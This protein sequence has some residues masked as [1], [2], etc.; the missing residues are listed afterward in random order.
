MRISLI[1][2]KQIEHWLLEQGKVQDR[3][4][5]EAKVLLSPELKEKA[6]WQ[7]KSYQLIQ[8]YGRNKLLKEIKEVEEQLF[9]SDKHHTF[10][11][12]IKSIFKY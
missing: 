6:Y 11:Q 5:T 12:K 4:I 10:Q 3:L 8:R 1:E 7:S 2:I 9:H